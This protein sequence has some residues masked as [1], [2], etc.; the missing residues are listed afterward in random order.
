MCMHCP[1][2]S[3]R[4]TQ[5][6]AFAGRIGGPEDSVKRVMLQGVA[7]S[8]QDGVSHS[9]DCVVCEAQYLCCDCIAGVRGRGHAPRLLLRHLVCDFAS[10]VD[11]VTSRKTRPAVRTN[12][13][14]VCAKCHSSKRQLLY[15]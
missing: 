4:Q 14:A 2:Q 5:S 13:F 15:L 9:C 6:E 3:P 7:F 10:S 12:S 11:A 1:G 8:W